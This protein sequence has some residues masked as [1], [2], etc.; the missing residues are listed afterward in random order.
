MPPATVFYV[1]VEDDL[2]GGRAAN[3]AALQLFEFV[4]KR[5]GVLGGLLRVRADLSTFAQA[6]AFAA[7]CA[8]V[9]VVS[10][11]AHLVSDNLGVSPEPR[12]T[13]GSVGDGPARGENVRAEILHLPA[14]PAE[15]AAMLES[16]VAPVLDRVLGPPQALRERTW[17]VFDPNAPALD[18][19][20]RG[21]PAPPGA[22]FRLCARFP[23]V[24][25]R[26][27]APFDLPAAAFAGYVTAVERALGRAAFA[28]T[29]T[30]L[31]EV[32]V[33][34]LARRRWQLALAESCT[35]GRV[36]A[37][38]TEVAGVSAHF[39]QGFVVY[40]DRAK[41]ELLGVPAETLRTH[42]AVS[43]EVVEQMAAGLRE[44]AGADVAVAVSGIA[45]PGGAGPGKPV[46]T[47]W[48]AV[49]GPAGV[50]ATVRHFDGTRVAVQT[51]AAW[52]ALDLV[53]RTCEDYKENR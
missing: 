2:F 39:E 13:V 8:R 33:Q 18:R 43:R 25:V 53:R 5:G 35:G 22:V 17:S 7:G 12:T 40:A 27:E 45:G 52:T 10:G 21:L 30:T 29:D 46:G 37:L 24:V 1:A 23:M 20:L 6:V 19:V 15:F 32:V 34:H 51:L 9:V 14:A 44:R 4:K 28:A 42:G 47:V 48:F 36:A 49:A 41:H 50:V 31:A 38:L 3:D 11:G 16:V 26:L